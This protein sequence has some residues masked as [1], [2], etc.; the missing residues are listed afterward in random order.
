M[1]VFGTILTFQ[2]PNLQNDHF[3]RFPGQLPTFLV[4]ESYIQDPQKWPILSPST[5]FQPSEKMDNTSIV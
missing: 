5:H 4:V 2:V 1:M 3:V